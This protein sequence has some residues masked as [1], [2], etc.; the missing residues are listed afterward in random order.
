MYLQWGSS[1]WRVLACYHLGSLF[2]DC[3][4]GCYVVCGCIGSQCFVS[5]CFE[6]GG[7]RSV[8][9][10]CV[11]CYC[12]LFWIGCVLASCFYSFLW[13]G[14]LLLPAVVNGLL[15]L[16]SPHFLLGW[17]AYINGTNHSTH[18]Q[19]SGIPNAHSHIVKN[20]IVLS[21]AWRWHCKSKHVSLTYV[22]HAPPS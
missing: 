7:R 22:N 17:M 13:G 1:M 2:A 18:C 5:E 8:H 19:P 12:F 6:E 9:L 4:P 16:C 21:L 10:F 11:V 20:F 14:C 15:S 3:S